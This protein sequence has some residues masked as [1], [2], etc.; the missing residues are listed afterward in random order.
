M[1]ALAFALGLPGFPVLLGVASLA[2]LVAAELF[3][4]ALERPSHRA[5]RRLAA[6]GRE[7]SEQ[8]RVRAQPAPSP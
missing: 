8:R 3:H 4:R 1:V 2:A 5:A 6:L 7:A